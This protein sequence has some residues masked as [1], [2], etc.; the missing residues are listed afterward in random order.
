VK[1]PLLAS[2]LLVVVG[3]A[4]WVL[5]SHP[6]RLD[7]PGQPTDQA[8]L[9]HR[10][11]AYASSTWVVSQAN[12]SMELRFFDR[13]EGGVC[14]NPTWPALQAMAATTPSLAHLVAQ[15]PVEPAAPHWMWPANQTA[16]NPGTLPHTRYVSLYP[17]AILLNDRLSA[18]TSPHQAPANILVVG[19]G[20]GVGIAVY[21]H[22]FPQASIDVV[23]I[24]QSVI[25]LVRDHYPLMRW[26]ETQATADGRPRLAMHALD[27]RQFI[28][29]HAEQKKTPYDIILLDAYTSGS[30][31]PPHLMTREF[32]VECAAAMTPDGILMSNIIGC[33][34]P[35]R[36]GS[37]RHQLLGGAIRSMMA[38]GFT[39]V[40]N[41]PVARAPKEPDRDE[42]KN[43]MVLASRAPLTAQDNP[44]GWERMR[45]FVPYPELERGQPLYHSRT[46]S[47]VEGRQLVAAAEPADL[48]DK[49]MPGLRGRLQL[50]TAD[51]FGKRYLSDDVAIIA[52]VRNAIADSYK[53][54]GKPPPAGWGSASSSAILVYD[55]IDWVD[56]VRQV[57]E[58][59]LRYS[60]NR[61]AHDGVSLVGAQGEGGIIQ[62]PPLFTDARPNADIYNSGE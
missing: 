58:S 62:D 41:L 26:L 10:D 4:G 29:L 34:L 49:R 54:K 45:A 42:L 3:I 18:N 15:E 46:V 14:L 11:S 57:W 51:I 31:I 47:L 56:H 5:R 22:H 19:L 40:Q 24:D 17:A 43:N 9:A 33:Y 1:A 36:P 59:T 25:D 12:N 2:V 21:A 52:S 35:T 61:N 44:A 16:P 60:R 50:R 20:S 48:L 7:Q 30:T 6:Y 39:Y 53:E 55:E 23:D 8:A 28:T 38:A 32:Y 27:A 13:V 37:T